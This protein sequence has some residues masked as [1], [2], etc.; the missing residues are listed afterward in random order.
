[1][2]P[3]LMIIEKTTKFLN[4][5]QIFLKIYLIFKLNSVKNVNFESGK[6]LLFS[7]QK[8]TQ[9][10]KTLYSYKIL[11]CARQNFFKIEQFLS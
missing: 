3:Q 1:M 2:D 6:I 5:E 11:M 10:F 8:R 4:I 9:K 7:I